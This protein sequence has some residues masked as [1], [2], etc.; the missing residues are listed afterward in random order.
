MVLHFKTHE[1]SQLHSELIALTQE[2]HSPSSRL[3]HES[4]KIHEQ[5]HI[6]DHSVFD[7]EPIASS[8]YYATLAL[9]EMDIRCPYLLDALR[10][11]G[12]RNETSLSVRIDNSTLPHHEEQRQLTS[13]HQK[14]HEIP[15]MISWFVAHNLLAQKDTCT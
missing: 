14:M 10:E 15:M 6:G 8:S 2:K 1:K 13:A 3:I 9:Q 5:V 4:I 7:I 11:A 12:R